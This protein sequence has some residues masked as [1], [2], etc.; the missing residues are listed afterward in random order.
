M[1]A[2]QCTRPHTAVHGHA[3]LYVHQQRTVA[4]SPSVPKKTLRSIASAP[5]VLQK[6]VFEGADRIVVELQVLYGCLVCQLHAV[7]RL[8]IIY[9]HWM[10]AAN[11]CACIYTYAGVFFHHVPVMVLR[12]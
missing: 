6:E 8:Q 2:H 4:G 9:G 12:P 3:A 11:T 1:N 7:G 5:D 10:P